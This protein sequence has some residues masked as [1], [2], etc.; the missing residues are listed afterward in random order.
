MPF[1]FSLSFQVS[2]R[3]AELEAR[4]R[5]LCPEA[6]PDASSLGKLPEIYLLANE[7]I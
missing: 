3:G 4:A 6:C 5:T 1:L 2:R 7:L